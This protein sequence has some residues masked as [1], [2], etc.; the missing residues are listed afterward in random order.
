[1]LGTKGFEEI[2]E[3][4]NRLKSQLNITK[5]TPNAFTLLAD[6]LEQ[7]LTKNKVKQSDNFLKL[8]KLFRFTSNKVVFLD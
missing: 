8:L 5:D 3:V 1:M 6:A 7:E 2:N 4:A